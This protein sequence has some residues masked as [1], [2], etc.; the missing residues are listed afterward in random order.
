MNGFKNQSLLKLN[1]CFTRAMAISWESMTYSFAL[2]DG[3]LGR[4]VL[5][6]WLYNRRK[7][8]VGQLGD[9][10]APALTSLD[11]SYP[12]MVHYETSLSDSTESDESMMLAKKWLKDCMEKHNDCASAFPKS[13]FLPTRLIEI[14][15]FDSNDLRIR[16]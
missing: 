7:E 13:T 1:M 6:E 16:L 4:P 15:G 12:E 11:V 9:C 10:E 14:E 3:R 5:S 8:Q 2:S